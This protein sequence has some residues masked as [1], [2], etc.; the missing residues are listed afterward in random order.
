M[1]FGK[2]LDMITENN[3]NPE[4]IFELVEKVKNSNLKDEK[5]VRSLIK[6][7]S[8][9]ARKEIDPLKEDML[10]KKIMNDGV[11]EDLFNLI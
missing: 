3:I 1:N 7:A 11:S 10:V 4:E 8:K 9:L 5:V 2:V 6:D